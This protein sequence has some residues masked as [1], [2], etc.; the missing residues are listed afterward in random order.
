MTG[1]PAEKIPENDPPM[2][3]TGIILLLIGVLWVLQ[4][5]GIVGGSFMTGQRQWFYIGVVTAVVGLALLAWAARRPSS[6]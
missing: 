3:T 4:G 1:G 2:K 6:P 5:L